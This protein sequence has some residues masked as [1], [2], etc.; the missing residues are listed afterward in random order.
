MGGAHVGGAH[1]GGAHVGGAHVERAY[2]EGLMWKELMGRGSWEGSY[3]IFPN[4]RRVESGHKTRAHWKLVG[5]D[6]IV[7]QGTS[8]F[9]SD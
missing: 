3:S 2:G 9:V 8:D 7:N 1:V 5:G 6:R 4:V